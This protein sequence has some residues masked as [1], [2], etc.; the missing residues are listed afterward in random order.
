[1]TRKNA[2]RGKCAKRKKVRHDAVLDDAFFCATPAR[3]PKADFSRQKAHFNVDDDHVELDLENFSL[4]E[5]LVP[6]QPLRG[7]SADETAS[8]E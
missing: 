1:M 5:F 4:C 6:C 2:S 8:P 7:E 3:V